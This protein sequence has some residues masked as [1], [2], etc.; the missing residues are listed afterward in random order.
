[1]RIIYIY[2]NYIIYIYMCL[3]IRLKPAI[4]HVA[5]LKRTFSQGFLIDSQTMK[6]FNTIKLS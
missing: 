3:P 2:I 5:I 1:M 6:L 4:K